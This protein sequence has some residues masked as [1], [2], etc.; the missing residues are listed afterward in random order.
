MLQ[1]GELIV[2]ATSSLPIINAKTTLPQKD[3]LKVIMSNLHMSKRS[4]HLK[5]GYLKKCGHN[6]PPLSAISV[7]YSFIEVINLNYV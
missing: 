1:W 6:Q 7:N 2:P 5:N 3:I 4:R